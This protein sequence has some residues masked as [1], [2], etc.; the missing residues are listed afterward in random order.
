LFWLLFGVRVESGAA[1]KAARTIVDSKA[2]A[3]VKQVFA[4]EAERAAYLKEHVEVRDLHIDPATKPGVDGGAVQPVPGLLL[5]SGVVVN[6]GDKAVGS[7]KLTI[8]LLDASGTVLGQYR[9][10][11]IPRIGLPAGAQHP[12]KFD[13]PEKKG[14]EGKFSHRIL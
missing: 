10:D 8:E 12:F 7:A 11:I 1:D 14:F 4:G 5:V 6:T 3:P 9:E 2:A 13:V